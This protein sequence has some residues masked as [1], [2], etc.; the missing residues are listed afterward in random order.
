MRNSALAA[1]AR[2]ATARWPSSV[3]ATSSPRVS[4]R[5]SPSWASVASAC[6]AAFASPASVRTI[7]SPSHIASRNAASVALS[8]AETS[9]P[10]LADRREPARPPREG[11][12]V[13][14]AGPG[15]AGVAG[16]GPA[17]AMPEDL[18]LGHRVAVQAIAP[19]DPAAVSPHA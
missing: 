2:A 5:S 17:G 3:A 1:D 12:L 4:G 14:R 8:S 9:E 16:G 7:P 18:G 13:D 19:V 10:S 6:A 11:P 15:R